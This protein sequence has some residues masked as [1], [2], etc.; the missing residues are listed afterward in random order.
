[1]DYAPI[2]GL[3]EFLDAATECIFQGHQPK[4]TYTSAVATPGGTGGIH[5]MI[6]N[7]VEKGETFLI[8]EWH[9]GPYREIATEVEKKWELYQMF[10]EK[11][12]FT[13][14]DLKERAK[15]LLE[16]QDSIMTI[17]NTPAHNPSGYTMTDEDW[18]EIMDFIKSA[19][20]TR[21]KNH[22][23]LGYGLHRLRWRSRRAADLYEG[24]RRYAG[25]YSRRHRLQ[26]VKILSD[27]WN[28]FRGAGMPDFGKTRCR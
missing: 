5:H 8:P 14:K 15:R 16:T 21:V 17:F 27:L 23:H 3:R 24:F 26:H 20:K 13:L 18:Q 10:D 2:E 28:A 7:Y 11:G 1:M 12:N 19:P 22:R 25:E 6:F 9:W 4:N